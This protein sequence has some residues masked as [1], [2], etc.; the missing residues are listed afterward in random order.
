MAYFPFMVDISGKRIVI[1]GGGRSA[2]WKVRAFKGFGAEIVVIAPEF[3]E[4]IEKAEG[5]QRIC[6]PFQESDLDGADVLVAATDD[7]ALNRRVAEM[8]RRRGVP[9]NA[10]DDKEMC[11]FIFPAIVRR[12]NYTVAIST[13][14]KSP[15][16]AREIK[17]SISRSLPDAYDRAVGELGAAR[18]KVKAKAQTQG[19][20]QQI[21]TAM[22]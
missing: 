5:I 1:V 4:E 14:G 18:Q 13:D 19:E 12:E 8:A 15:L 17:K 16:L 11:D 10:V 22:A 2:L 3:R 6:R 21:F 20:R 7:R 9:V